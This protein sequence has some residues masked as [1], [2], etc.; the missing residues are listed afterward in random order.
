M[1]EEEREKI[2]SSDE[3]NHHQE[4]RFVFQGLLPY[5]HIRTTYV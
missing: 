2:F 1:K 5:N 4:V 3:S